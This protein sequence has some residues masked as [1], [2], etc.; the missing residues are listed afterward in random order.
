MVIKAS[1]GTAL[2]NEGVGMEGVNGAFFAAAET[3]APSAV[4][5]VTV[6][7]EVPAEIPETVPGD[8]PDVWGMPEKGTGWCDCGEDHPVDEPLVR[9]MI[10]G[11]LGDDSA[12]V[13]THA[14]VCEVIMRMWR[15]YEV[16]RFFHD[17]VER[18]A[19]AM[20]GKVDD[21]YAM[22][23]GI[24]IIAYFAKTWNG[25]PEELCGGGFDFDG[26]IGQS[27]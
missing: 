18:S 8:R 26:P 2:A 1:C 23:V 4:S 17:A 7:A 19:V 6:P 22:P 21:E 13:I 27:E 9:S 20:N 3:V 16:C 24:E 11:V 10:R 25:C 12:D 15:Y 14:E 5:P